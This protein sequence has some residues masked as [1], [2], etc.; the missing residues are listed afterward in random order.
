MLKH[1]QELQMQKKLQG[2]ND[3]TQENVM[4]KLSLLHNKQYSGTKYG[5]L[6]HGIRV[7][8]PSQMFKFGDKNLVQDFSNKL[9]CP[10][11]QGWSQESASLLTKQK[12]QQAGT[13]GKSSIGDQ[14][15]SDGSSTQDLA[16][17][18]PLEHKILIKKEEG[19]ESFEKTDNSREFPLIRGGNWSAPMQSAVAEASS[20]DPGLQEERSDLSFQNPQ[21]S[22]ENRP[23]SLVKSGTHPTS[24]LHNKFHD[25]HLGKLKTGGYSGMSGL[26][27]RSLGFPAPNSSGNMLE[28]LHKLEK[29]HTN[30]VSMSVVPKS[31]TDDAYSPSYNKSSHSPYIGLGLNPTSERQS[32]NYFDP[33]RIS[34]QPERFNKPSQG[35][36]SNNSQLP[37]QNHMTSNLVSVKKE[38]G[39]EWSTRSVNTWMDVSTQQNPF[40]I[41][42]CEF[43]ST[44]YAANSRTKTAFE[45]SK[46][47]R[48]NELLETDANV[49]KSQRFED[50]KG[51]PGERGVIKNISKLS[52]LTSHS[53]L[54]SSS[55]L[56]NHEASK[57]EQMSSIYDARFGDNA[58]KRLVIKEE[59]G[60]LEKNSNSLV[61][62]ASINQCGTNKVALRHSSS[63]YL[64]HLDVANRN[65]VVS[66]SKKRKYTVFEGLPW[67]KEVTE[68][69]SRL[70]DI[71]TTELEWA[72][73]VVRLPE[74]LKELAAQIASD[75]RWV[76]QRKRR[77][78][79]TTQLMQMLFRPA[80]AIFLSEDATAHCDA[81]IYYAAKLALGDA[82][83]LL[84][85]EW[86]KNLTSRKGSIDHDILQSIQG[87]IDRSKKMEDEFSRLE[88]G[89]SSVLEVRMDF[90]D[91]EK[92]SVNNRLAKFHGRKPLVTASSGVASSM[93]K[94]Y[95]QRYVKAIRMPK[96]VPEGQ[97]CLCL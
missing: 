86:K 3:A 30:S 91:L 56:M 42:S 96:M 80:P 89:E 90:Q 5:L 97:K 6:N 81:V 28:L 68:S 75:S 14:S 55:N 27:D 39:Q 52:Q 2:V 83:S 84:T 41:K 74:K 46:Y 33:S 57:T 54:N 64:H 67:H 87:F 92:I 65:M 95:P 15:I 94:L 66:K 44:S 77:L 17:F 48:G 71:S 26:V 18:D 61:E 24:W 21:L 50:K 38:D 82:C 10:R 37:N 62:V 13:F 79:L 20:S 76:V 58:G 25:T 36:Q 22:N 88:K 51:F 85:L 9:V 1:L 29:E 12:S 69:S 32:V 16:N 73:S 93:P 72:N 60:S 11:I 40:V 45:A 49:R 47:V 63:V 43:P 8:D 34:P 35:P 31:E 7:R 23:P 59:S 4:D 53:Q 70:H 19:T 78:N